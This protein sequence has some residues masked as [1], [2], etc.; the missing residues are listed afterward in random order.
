MVLL[1]Y[2]KEACQWD[3]VE[4][5]RMIVASDIQK[6]ALKNRKEFQAHPHWFHACQQ[7]AL[8]IIFT[9]YS[10][11]NRI[12][13]QNPHAVMFQMHLNF[14]LT[15]L[16]LFGFSFHSSQLDN[17]P[18]IFLLLASGYLPCFPQPFSHPFHC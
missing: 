10:K 9:V 1:N 12:I 18:C 4:F 5:F 2:I 13:S 6:Y 17:L 15:S 11:I 3:G 14:T 8:S 7:M 16:Q